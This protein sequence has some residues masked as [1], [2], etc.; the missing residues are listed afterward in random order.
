[1]RLY[2][3]LS[4][5]DPEHRDAVIAIG[6]FDGAHRGHRAL[7]AQAKNKAQSLNKKLGVLTFEPHPRA[8]FRPDDPPFRITP[9]RLKAEHLGDAGADFIVALPFDWSF[10]S[11]SAEDF[12]AGILQDGFGAAHVMVGQ[13]FRFGQLRKGTP[14]MIEASGIPVTLFEDVR[15]EHGMRY[16]S[17]AVREALRQGDITTANTILGWEWHIEGE[18]RHGDR[19]GHEIGY[20]TANVG[21]GDTLH[22]AYG[23]YAAWVQIEGEDEWRMAAVNIGIRPMFELQVGQVEAY[24]LDFPDRDIYGRSL[25]IRPVARLRGEAKFDGLPALIAQIG[26]DVAETRRILG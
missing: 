5:L 3:S 25:K 1:M 21:M 14:E 22:P 16:S 24:I 9:I 6:N 17:S 2:E 12:M 15:D 11:Q 26:A 8:L 20:P 18:I 10:A 13:D 7:I 19:R 4:F 23:V